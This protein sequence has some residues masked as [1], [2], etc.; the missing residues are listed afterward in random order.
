MIYTIRRLAVSLA[1]LPVAFAGYGV[2]YF[3]LALVANSFASVENY[4]GNLTAIG[5]AWVIT[6][7]FSKQILDTINR[8][9]E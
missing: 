8:I 4:V 9:G 6:I 1:T 2:I 5:F 7:T 3:G